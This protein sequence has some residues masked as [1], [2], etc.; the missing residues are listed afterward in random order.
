LTVLIDIRDT[1]IHLVDK[2][3]HGT[4]SYHWPSGLTPQESF[5]YFRWGKKFIPGD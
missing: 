3:A 1:Q 2:E 5:F 4:Y